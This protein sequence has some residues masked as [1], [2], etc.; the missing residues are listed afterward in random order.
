MKAKKILLWIVVLALLFTLRTANCAQKAEKRQD[1]SAMYEQIQLFSDAI[2]IIQKNYVDTIEPKKLIYGALGGMLRALDPY[3]QFMDPDMYNEIKVETTGKFGGLGIEISI[4]DNLLTV[5]APID[6]TPAYKAGIKALDRIV[7]I[8]NESTRDITLLEAVKKLRGE[9]GTTVDVTVLREGEKKLLDFTIK[10]DIIK[11]DSL[12][13][14]EVLEGD[15]GYIRLI[16]F[17]Q[18]TSKELDKALASLEVKNIKG[19]IL[20]LRD[21]PGGLLDSAVDVSDKF[22]HNNEIIVTTKGRQEDQVLEFRAR[23]KGALH[24]YPIAILVN[25]GSASASEIVAGAIQDNKRG[26][27][28]GIKTFGKGSVQTVVPLPDGSAL[29]ITTAKYLTPSGRSIMND[30]IEPDVVVEQKEY[31]ESAKENAEDIFESLEEKDLEKALEENKK[32]YDHQ[33][34]TGINILRGIIAYNGKGIRD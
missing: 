20:D 2:T 8:N 30:G 11:V 34:S 27:V 5:I 13:K 6:G 4:R 23:K 19:L 1:M 22:L 33:L 24:D 18:D 26:L 28:I 32:A 25:G 10:R 17:Q 21:N 14:A 16:E 12:K 15:I 29:R 7:K 9:P 31:K 3:S